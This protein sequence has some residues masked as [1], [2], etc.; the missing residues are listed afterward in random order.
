MIKRRVPKT[1]F[2]DTSRT[3]AFFL[4]QFH[5][6]PQVAFHSSYYT[7]Q[8]TVSHSNYAARSTVSHSNY[9]AR[10]TVSHRNYA[11]ESAA[12]HIVYRK[13]SGIPTRNFHKSH[14]REMGF[15]KKSFKV[16]PKYI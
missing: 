2:Y 4:Y 6:A 11:T 10:S 9:A 1:C 14:S 3:E 15:L 13:L 7:A 5:S 8:N 16:E 12:S